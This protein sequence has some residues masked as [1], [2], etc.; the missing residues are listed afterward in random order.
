MKLD[1]WTSDGIGPVYM[2]S[3]GNSY[4]CFLVLFF[5]KTVIVQTVI[6]V[7]NNFMF[8]LHIFIICSTFMQVL[9]SKIGEIYR[10]ICDRKE[11]ADIY[12]MSLVKRGEEKSPSLKTLAMS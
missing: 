3:G 11:I 2:M 8:C 1:F 4:K 10:S 9:K 7:N 12:T 5:S 6:A